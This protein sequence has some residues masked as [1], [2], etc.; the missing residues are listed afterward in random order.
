MNNP[1]VENGFLSTNASI[2]K[3]FI[4]KISNENL[5]GKTAGDIF[6]TDLLIKEIIKNAKELK[7]DI[8]KTEHK[9][10]PKYLQECL[11][12]EDFLLKETANKIA[13]LFGERLGVILLNLKKGEKESREKRSDWK[14]E[15]WDYWAQIENVIL[16]GGLASGK[17]GKN[18][19]KAIYK[20]FKEEQEEPYK[21]ILVDNSS[22]IGILGCSK[23]VKNSI[24]NQ[25]NLVF[26]FGQSFIKRSLVKLGNNNGIIDE[27]IKLQNIKSQNVGWEFINSSEEKEE[28]R[29]LNEHLVSSIIETLKLCNENKYIIGSEI[30]IS[31]A[32]YIKDGKVVNRGGYGKLGLI[33]DNY[34]RY[35]EEA[36]FREFNKEYKVK[37]IHDGTAMAAAFSEYENSVCI[38]L[39]TALGVGFPI[40]N[41]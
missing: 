23:F 31:I 4:N 39:G 5:K 29:A 15:H 12:S 2:N 19:E 16:V 37:M 30:I 25:Y 10:L 17:L 26:D 27:V 36:L 14:N 32:N 21:I 40:K 41:N 34:E 20:V 11:D 1:F 18:L 38:S 6:S 28:A 35:L 9:L 22:E 24:E 7:L 8:S 33:T 13:D 3:L